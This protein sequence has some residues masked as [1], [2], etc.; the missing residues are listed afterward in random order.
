MH[1]V[2]KNWGYE[3]W[4]ENNSGYCCK[5]L[6]VLPGKFCSVH[7]HKNK[8]ESFYVTKGKMFLKLFKPDNNEIKI[9]DDF[10]GVNLSED[11]LS[12]LQKFDSSPWEYTLEE[13]EFRTIDTY[14][15]HT[16]SSVSNT[17][18]EFIE[19]SSHHEDSDSYRLRKSI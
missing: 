19:A 3:K 5:L 9:L 13:G 8:K 11:L 1:I 15:L 7:F 17:N 4:V 10:D 6:H 18:C 12:I 16:F 14:T 2:M